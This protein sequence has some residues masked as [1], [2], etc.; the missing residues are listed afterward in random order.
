MISIS[1]RDEVVLFDRRDRILVHDRFV[2]QSTA[3]APVRLEVRIEAA[4]SITILVLCDV[5]HKSI[6]A[7]VKVE[8]RESRRVPNLE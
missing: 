7:D 5:S 6:G 3:T 8:S 4:E 1:R 2:G